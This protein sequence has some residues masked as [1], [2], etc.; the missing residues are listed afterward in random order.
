[1]PAAYDIA[2]EHAILV[3]ASAAGEWRAVPEAILFG[4]LLGMLYDL[5]RVIGTTM[6]SHPTGSHPAGLRRGTVGENG[7]TA[8]LCRIRCRPVRDTVTAA[9]PMRRGICVSERVMQFLLDI[10]YFLLCG[11]LGA[12]FLYWRNSGILRWYLILCGG[13]GFWAYT[14]TVG[15]LVMR[16]TAFVFACV[17][18]LLCTAFNR[19]VYYPLHIGDRACAALAAR[20]RRLRIRVPKQKT[21]G[22]K[23]R[24]RIGALWQSRKNSQRKKQASSRRSH[25]SS[26]SDSAP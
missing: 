3:E 6:G 13:L 16:L 22:T 2:T 7:L 26:S 1:M 4:I 23:K 19:I 12:V 25:F 5:F 11:I 8:R 17:H 21:N 15:V 18:A 24:R 10:F 14:R 9:A 20:M